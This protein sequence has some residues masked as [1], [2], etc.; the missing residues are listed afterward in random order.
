[1]AE[2]AAASGQAQARSCGVEVV[3]RVSAE[4][5]E[6]VLGDQGRVQR[7]L[8]NLLSHRL[9]ACTSSNGRGCNNEVLLLSL[10]PWSS[11]RQG[12]VVIELPSSPTDL[13]SEFASP[14][15]QADGLPLSLQVAR[16]LLDVLG[17]TATIVERKSAGPGVKH[18][19]SKV[20]QLTLSLAPVVDPVP[21]LGEAGWRWSLPWNPEVLVVDPLTLRAE[22][23]S[24]MLQALGL[25]HQ[26]VSVVPHDF[27]EPLAGPWDVIII[28][29]P[30][31]GFGAPGA[32]EQVQRGAL[33]VARH[34]FWAHSSGYSGPVPVGS[35]IL[36]L[37]LSFIILYQALA[38]LKKPLD[39][40]ASRS[41]SSSV[42]IPSPE[43]QHGRESAA[44]LVIDPCPTNGHSTR[45]A[46]RLSGV[47][48]VLLVTTPSDAMEI[49]RQS[50]V[51]P[52]FV[53]VGLT[54]TTAG[55]PRL[56]RGERGW[57]SRLVGLVWPGAAE[58]EENGE[59]AEVWFRP[60]GGVQLSSCLRI[61]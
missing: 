41:A 1:M 51:T 40:D 38:G 26:A 13:F 44:I 60:L 56:L 50:T 20:L 47:P 10:T 25:R 53:L 18:G 14:Q 42:L 46:L 61:S 28:C 45:L 55:L 43:K 33:G 5:P 21:R 52:E 17:G 3:A 48:E 35:G 49:V 30:N 31:G 27:G 2:R 4:L 59:F 9:T 12:H 37:P 34:V 24:E 7:V 16:R 15:S 11:Q 22:A 19:S 58:A 29:G 6:V 54:Q 23:T 32:A 57:G 8:S 36:P 39:R